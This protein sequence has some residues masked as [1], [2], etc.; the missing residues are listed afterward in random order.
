MLKQFY[1]FYGNY[2][3]SIGG[4]IHLSKTI[5]RAQ[6]LYFNLGKVKKDIVL[7]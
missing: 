6:K 1:I 3:I 2:A 4:N 7:P 5:L